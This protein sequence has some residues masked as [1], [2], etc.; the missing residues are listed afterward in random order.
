VAIVPNS[1]GYNT[2]SSHVRCVSQLLPNNSQAINNS[3]V[4][5]C[6]A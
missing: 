6:W 5:D 1:L 2:L 3:R 4:S